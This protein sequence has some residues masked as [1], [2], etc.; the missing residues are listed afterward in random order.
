MGI[1]GLKLSHRGRVEYRASVGDGM[2]EHEVVDI[3]VADAPEDLEITPNPDEVMGCRWIGVY[4]LAAEIQRHP[5]RFTPWIKIY[6]EQH[7]ARI[8]GPR[9]PV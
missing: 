8:F 6:M 7:M 4:D 9:I 5:H 1:R 2:T 3:Y